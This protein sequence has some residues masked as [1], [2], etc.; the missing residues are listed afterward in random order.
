M[1]YARSKPCLDFMLGS[2]Y[3]FHRSF[4]SSVGHILLRDRMLFVLIAIAVSS[5]YNLPKIHEK[6]DVKKTCLF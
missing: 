1:K 6:R 2:T 4:W 5:T 3:G